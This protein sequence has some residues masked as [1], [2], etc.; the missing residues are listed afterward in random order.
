M[1]EETG[2]RNMFGQLAVR[3]EHRILVF[4][5]R[6]VSR[7]TIWTYNLSTEKWRKHE[8]P[9]WQITPP[10]CYRA[11]AAAIG[12]DVYM[13]DGRNYPG[14][15]SADALWKLSRSAEGSM[16]WSRVVIKN[17][18]KV[19]SYRRDHSGWAYEDKL[20]VF[21]GSET[22]LPYSAGYLNGFGQF[23]NPLLS[24]GCYTNQL[25][26]FNPANAEWKN[27]ECDGWVP[28][29]R[30]KHATTQL[31]DKVW[32]YGGIDV[33]LRELDDMYELS[34]RS[35][36]WTQLQTAFFQPTPQGRALGTLRVCT[37]NKLLLHGGTGSG[38]KRDEIWI[39]DLQSTSWKKHTLA[40]DSYH[41]LGVTG[42]HS[43][44]TIVGGSSYDTT[45]HVM[46]EPR[47]RSLQQLA[48]QTIDKPRTLLGWNCLP[49]KL[50]D[51]LE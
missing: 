25:L 33:N 20:W 30:G 18:T 48:I 1:A 31:N 12:S 13:F 14:R 32:L 39:L 38:I 6:D 46:F 21:G 26:C 2:P 15:T 45:S 28:T 4:G 10:A 49:N 44:V 22:E 41:H 29:P 36:W 50:I 27:P 40:K 19:P 23:T 47:T 34:M 9:S 42:L 51:Q 35:L 16:Y 43:P 11:C 8:I 3:L 5:G 37:E 24:K 17:N 7:H